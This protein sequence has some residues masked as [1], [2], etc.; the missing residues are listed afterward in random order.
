MNT[1][2]RMYALLDL[3]D[4]ILLEVEVLDEYEELIADSYSWKHKYRLNTR[5]EA[6]LASMTDEWYHLVT[7]MLSAYVHLLFE[8]GRK[9]HESRN[10]SE[11]RAG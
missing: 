11:H 8:K 4:T 5:N 10:P 2:H 1:Y 6:V 3:M 7:Q 9:E